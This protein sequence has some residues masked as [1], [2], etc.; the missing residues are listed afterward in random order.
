MQPYA[1]HVDIFV[2]TGVWFGVIAG[3]SGS[4]ASEYTEEE[5]E[6]FRRDPSA[7]VEHAR[8][9]EGQVNGMVREEGLLEPTRL[10]DMLTF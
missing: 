1:K 10:R 2:R 5:R 7:I 6:K 4:Q 3:N 8:E 9:I